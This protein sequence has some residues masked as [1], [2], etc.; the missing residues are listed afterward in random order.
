VQYG[1][2]VY[3][4][5]DTGSAFTVTSEV[6]ELVHVPFP[7]TYLTVYG[8]ADGVLAAR[9]MVPVR[10]SITSPAVEEYVPPDCPAWV[11]VAVPLAQYGEPG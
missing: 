6:V 2:A 8:V 4:I 10:G 7:N 11:T 9:L 5:V 3:A 1:L